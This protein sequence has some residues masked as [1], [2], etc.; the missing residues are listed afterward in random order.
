MN[1]R[2]D[3]TPKLPIAFISF[4]CVAAAAAAA[5]TLPTWAFWA[6]AFRYS[7]SWG[8]LSAAGLL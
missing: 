7:T 5:A 2:S 8:P 4:P 1:R 6:L 3:E